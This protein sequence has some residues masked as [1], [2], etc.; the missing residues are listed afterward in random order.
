MTVLLFS[1]S[2]SIISK[3]SSVPDCKKMD[4]EVQNSFVDY[5]F[6]KTGTKQISKEIARGPLELEWSNATRELKEIFYKYKLDSL[7]ADSVKIVYVRKKDKKVLFSKVYPLE[8]ANGKLLKIKGFLFEQ[9]VQKP[10]DRPG[11]QHYVFQKKKRPI[12]QS[13]IGHYHATDETPN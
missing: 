7:K 4:I 12:C 1:L 8:K 2:T 10:S 6:D 3:E 11:V 9:G 5:Q 13:V